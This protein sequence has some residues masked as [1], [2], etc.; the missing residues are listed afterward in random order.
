[1]GFILRL[2]NDQQKVYDIGYRGM[3][4]TIDA[5][6]QHGMVGGKGMPRVF[7]ASSGQLVTSEQCAAARARCRAA[8][9]SD[10]P[11]FGGW[12]RWLDLAKDNGGF[13]VY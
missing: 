2:G 10:P 1:M 3:G 6:R 8:R 13:Y 9:P 4:E 7:E 12:L 11:W 5:M